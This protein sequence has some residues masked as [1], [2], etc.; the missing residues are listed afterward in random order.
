M[1]KYSEV[2]PV[3]REIIESYTIRLTVRQIFYRLISPPYQLFAGTQ[4]NYKQFDRILTRAREKGDI[5]WRRIEDRART[6]LG[7]D[8]GFESPEEFINYKIK[9]FKNSWMFYD[10][11]MWDEQDCYVEIWLE[12]DALATL[13]SEVARK[14]RVLVFP[15][16]GY[17]SFTKIMEALTDSDRFPRYIRMGKPIVILHFS[18]HDPSGLNMTVDINNR[19]FKRDYLVRGL[20][21]VFSSE[22]LEKIKEL[23]KG[24][25]WLVKV[26]RCALTYEQVRRYNLPPNPTKKADPRSKWYV[27]QYGDQCW[28]LDAVEPSELQR[29]I[30]NSILKWINR[31]KW[32]ETV[33]KIEGEKQKLKE[34]FEKAKISF[35]D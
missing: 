34:K 27:Q 10:R 26:E 12:K 4:N 21:E 13:F 24:K 6:T 1:M 23:F 22:E 8:Y 16:R 3:V 30:E 2:V 29:I 31:E 5:D 18:D 7:G 20:A 9:D 15:S 32:N 19:L 28:E 11:R 25:E 14:Y 17:S 35:E 33:K